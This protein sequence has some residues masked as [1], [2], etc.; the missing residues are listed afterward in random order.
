MDRDGDFVVAWSSYGQDSSSWGVYA[1]RY[2]AAG[3]CQGTEFRVNTYTTNFQESPRVA[4]SDDGNFVIAWESSGQ[5]GSATGVY[6]QY[7]PPAQPRGRS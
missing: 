7:D 2:N 6:A 3:V 5:D 4:L 1:Q